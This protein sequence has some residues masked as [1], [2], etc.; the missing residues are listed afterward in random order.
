LIENAPA[1]RAVRAAGVDS[2]PRRAASEGARDAVEPEPAEPQP[3]E[4][5]PQE[6]ARG[7]PDARAVAAA[8]GSLAPAAPGEAPRPAARS[9]TEFITDGSLAALCCALEKLTGLPVQLRDAQGRRVVTPEGG[10]RGWTLDDEPAPQ[11][12][13]HAPIHLAGEPV[14][15]VVLGRGEVRL[16]PDA[17]A[18]VE[19]VVQLLALSAQEVVEHEEEARHHIKELSALFRLSSL[20]TRAASVDRVLNVAL[21]LALDTL[22]LDAGSIVLLRERDEDDAVLGDFEEDVVLKASRN[23]S[24]DWLSSPLPLSRQRVFDTLAAQ[25]QVVAVEDLQQDERVLIKERAAREGL[26]AFINA[27]LVVRSRPIGVIRLYSRTPRRFTEE[28]RRLL[29]SIADQAG[30]AVE[31]AR[32][33]RVEEEEQRIQRQ[34]LMAADIQRRMLP[35]RSPS[36]GTLDVSGRHVP[37][38]ELGGDFY[39]FMELNG[40]L[41]VVI[42]DVVGK[43]IAAALLM[44]A[45]RA[46]LR[47]HV[48][49]VYDLN[50][51]ILRVNQAL[52]LD[53]RDHEFV[54]LWYG[55]V[56]PA[57]LRLTYCS[58]GHDP[59]LVFRPHKTGSG[60]PS[61]GEPARIDVFELDVGGMVLGIDAGQTYERGIFQ[62]RAGDVLLGTT[63]GVMDTVNYEGRKFGRR[64]VRD[65]VVELLRSEP[66]ASASRIAEHMMWAL[67][68]HAGLAARADD[69]TV[70]ALRVGAP[71]AVAGE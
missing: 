8:A 27:G 50:E 68:Q 71:T 62:L 57:S 4:S 22:G 11:H 36:V 41:G 70:V 43:G 34:V 12:A 47:A 18:L 1:A 66:A 15:S 37:S 38:F 23:L 7:A 2:D 24:E 32:L 61:G 65:T 19:R 67:R 21:E 48:Q 53:T 69:Q 39:D 6:P 40:H 51:V 52:C 31:Q 16:P 58:A 20:L 46:S 3:T 60:G 55:V 28:E 45:V 9:I 13:T 56:D 10:A 59:V 30:V 54:T 17:R 14:G 5:Q 64:A 35:Q 26:A 42:G 29:K 44:S 33:R 63:D 25:G 49:E